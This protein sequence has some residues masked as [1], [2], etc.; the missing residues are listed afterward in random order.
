[1][2]ARLHKFHANACVL[3]TCL[4]LA[5]LRVRVHL[6]RVSAGIC[7]HAHTRVA[8]RVCNWMPEAG[9]VRSRLRYAML[10]SALL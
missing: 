8:L 1:M 7:T 5:C 9:K 6:A 2:C 3:A 10:F 4:S